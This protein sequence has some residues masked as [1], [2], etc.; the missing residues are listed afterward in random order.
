MNAEVVWASLKGE[1]VML[2]GRPARDFGNAGNCK[3]GSVKILPKHYHNV[4]EIRY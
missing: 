1:R 2:H 4:H 3:S